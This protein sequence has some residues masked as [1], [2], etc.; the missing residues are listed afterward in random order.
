MTATVRLLAVGTLA[1]MLAGCSSS[2]QP[3][4]GPANESA[5]TTAGSAPSTEPSA[6]ASASGVPA[7]LISRWPVAGRDEAIAIAADATSVWVAESA[8]GKPGTLLR[9]DGTDGAVVH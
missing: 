8:Y 7:R 9:I 4:A 3:P 5:R 2:T 1:V 6:Y